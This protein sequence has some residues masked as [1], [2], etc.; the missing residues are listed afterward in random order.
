MRQPARILALAILL[1]VAAA[2]APLKIV[3][4]DCADGDSINKALGKKDT[5]LI[6]NVQGVCVEDVVVTRDRVTLRG[7]DP[8]VD[9][10]QAATAD[11]PFGAS[12][13]VRG[14]RDVWIE[15]LT[16][17]GGRHAGLRVEDS[18]RNVNVVN[19]RLEGNGEF[20]IT[21]SA[22]L[23]VLTDVV[24]TGN[25]FVGAGVSETAVLVCIDCTIVDNP[26]A[27]GNRAA[28]SFD[29]TPCKFVR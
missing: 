17:G 22:S 14:A 23:T 2:A 19:S 26:S 11:D 8:A 20:G 12:L 15:N 1:P 13:L 7:T 27:D 16:L 3:D 25:G 28:R 24:I 29:R 18:R 21:L 9:G 6:I 4:V 5:E 10:I